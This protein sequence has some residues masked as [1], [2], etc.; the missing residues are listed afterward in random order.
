[1][2]NLHLTLVQREIKQSKEKKQNFCFKV[3]HQLILKELICKQ[4]MVHIRPDYFAKYK[5]KFENVDF[6]IYIHLREDPQMK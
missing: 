4:K 5:T 1:M 6:K 3:D 2:I